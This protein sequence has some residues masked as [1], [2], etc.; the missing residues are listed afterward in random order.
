M[1]AAWMLYTLAVTLL[2]F[3]GASAAEFLARAVGIPARFVWAFAILAALGLS[4]RALTRAPQPAHDLA[5]PIVASA[6]FGGRI[7]IDTAPAAD[8]RWIHVE[9]VG[10]V[11]RFLTAAR[12]AAVV[13]QNAGGRLAVVRLDVERLERWNDALVA[14]CI[15]ASCLAFIWLAGSLVNLRR[16]ERELPAEMV[17]ND[18][19]L[20]SRDVGPAIFGVVRSRI[21]LPRWVL[22]L[23]DAERRIILS[24]ERQ[25]AAAFDPAMLYAAAAVLALQPWNPA[26][27]ALFTRLRFGLEAD[28][29]RRVLGA[30]GD[31]LRYGK[32]LV[33]VYERTIPARTPYVAFVERPSN[34]ERRIRR[35]TRRPRLLSMAGA[36]SLLATLVLS[37]AA[38]TMSAPVRPTVRATPTQRPR[39]WRLPVVVPTPLGKDSTPS[40]EPEMDTTMLSAVPMA[41]AFFA[42]LTPSN[43]LSRVAVKEAALRLPAVALGSRCM[44][45]EQVVIS[46]ARESRTVIPTPAFRSIIG[47]LVRG[48]PPCTIDGDIALVALDS[49]HVLVAWRDTADANMPSADY[50]VFTVESGSVPANLSWFTYN[51]HAEFT[52]PSFY[53]ASPS[54]GIP[55]VA[56]GAS[57]DDLRARHPDA[58]RL[59]VHTFDLRRQTSITWDVLRQLPTS[60]RCASPLF[61]VDG[62]VVSRSEADRSRTCFVVGGQSI[63]LQP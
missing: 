60:P 32:L 13:V 50:F 4:A 3:A 61:I 54:A 57:P 51:G 55:A 40:V 48:D 36:S 2:L 44:R 17:D 35:M 21:V 53:L 29:D 7:V 37:T 9:R 33:A 46:V 38:W 39:M 1:I 8:R 28:C 24:H 11:Q 47:T 58:L 5:A 45:N 56:F 10:K 6:G 15:A 22:S 63:Q 25:H 26:L 52:G 34:L 31:A 43:E 30:G 19:V 27:W 42:S 49:S 12:G 18:V 59:V 62:V 14:L 23:P 16:I 41:K 20:V